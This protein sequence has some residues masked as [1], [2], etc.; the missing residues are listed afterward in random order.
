MQAIRLANGTEKQTN[1]NAINWR[2]ANRTVRHLR[3]RIFRAAQE[4]NLNKVRSLQKLMLKSYSNR[5]VSVRRV[6]QINAG[7]DT[8]GMD[9]L[10]IKT[11]AARG[12]MVDSLAHYSL[13]KAKPTRRVYIPKASSSKLRPLGIPIWAVHYP[14]SQ[15]MFG[16]SWVLLLVDRSSRS[17]VI[18]I[19][20]HKLPSMTST[21]L[22]P[23]SPDWL[24][25]LRDDLG[26]EGD[27][28]RPQRG[29]THTLHA[30]RFAPL[31][32][33]RDIY[34][35]QF[36]C[37]P[38]RVAPISSLS[39]R[40]SL[41]TFGASS[42]DVIG[43]PNPLNF[44]DRKRASHASSLSFLIEQGGN[45]R[46]GLRRR[47][48]AHALDH[49]WAGLSFLPR[50]FVARDGKARERLGLPANG[51]INDVAPLGERH[52][53]D[54]PTHQLLAL[55]EGCRGSMPDGWQ[56]LR[57]MTDLLP[58]RGGEQEGGLFGH[59][60][61]F[62]LQ[63]LDL[64]QFLIPLSFQAPGHQ[65]IVRVD[66]LVASTSQVRFILRPLDLAVPLLIGLPGTCFH[67]SKRREGYLQVGRLDGLQETLDH[68]LI[69]AISPHGL[70]G[71]PGE[72]R[73]DLVTFVHQ[74]RAIALIANRHAPATRAAQDNAL[75][76][77]WTFTNRSSML[78][79]TPGAVIVELPLVAQKLFPGD[80]AR[81]GV[82]Q[83]DGP[84]FLF[85]PAGSP[86]DARLF[87]RKG[88]PPELGAP[89]DV[90]SRIQGAMQD[91]QDPLMGQTT[92]DQFIGLLASPP[93]GRET[94][95][96]L[97]KVAD[98]GQCR[99][100]LLKER[101]HQ[102]NGFGNGLIGIEHD[103]AHRIVDEA[104]GQTKAQLSLLGLRQLAPLQTLMQPMKLG[105]RHIALESEQQTIIIGS[106]IIDAFFV[107]DERVR[108]RTNFQQPIPVAA[109]ASQARDL[110]AEHGPNVPQTHFSHQPL[111]TI[112]ANGRGARLPLILVHHLDA[113][114]CPSQVLSPL[115]QVIL[116]GRAPAIFSHLEQGRLPDVNDGETVKMV[117]TDFLGWL[118]AEH[119]RPPL[120]YMH[121]QDEQ[122][123]S[124]LTEPANQ[125]YA[126]ADQERGQATPGLVSPAR[127]EKTGART[128]AHLLGGQRSDERRIPVS[129]LMTSCRRIALVLLRNKL[130]HLPQSFNR[131]QRRLCR[132][133]ISRRRARIIRQAGSN[134]SMIAIR[135]AN[136]EVGIGPS[137]DANELHALTVQ[138]MMGMGHRDPFQRWLIKGGNVL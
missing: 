79:S 33:G 24:A 126:F 74:Q 89:V 96:L 66:S 32:D 107:N 39:G 42:R 60:G 85:D 29:G 110:Q 67:L 125:R 113:G 124:T 18:V 114:G 55:H 117:R 130:G 16:I 51:D 133:G 135:H 94:Q 72:L 3:Q 52:I 131:E 73:M 111:K 134:R 12:N 132:S 27:P 101:E 58:L 47:Q 136:D 31:G 122:Q 6:T 65:T 11:P 17:T 53:L 28:A 106:W 36:R 87:T 127:H 70:A 23:L 9:K 54:Q 69:N 109:R 81:M 34:I 100:V 41:R 138:G 37:G 129:Y 50:L 49:L 121:W 38:R 86:F 20:Y 102:A 83:H 5:L 90:G 57:K 88:T 76:E 105:L 78:L 14:S 93:A 19:L 82:Q 4:G 92:P 98:H 115:H 15:S 128:C 2:K 123:H 10:V 7:K 112:A 25:K 120:L 40:C 68:G 46:I 80:V 8:P 116:P 13:W 45:L 22:L 63:L 108:E 77:R 103:L 35:E 30:S 95:V 61:I 91:V 56:I 59:Q 62:S 118:S 43:I 137:A 48:L 44:A 21:S 97:G 104:N 71:F 84:V 26:G 99:V 75:Q 119:Q 1:W 64:S